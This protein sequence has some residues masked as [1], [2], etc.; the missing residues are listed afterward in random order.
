MPHHVNNMASHLRD[1]IRMSPPIFF[2]S[3]EDEDPQNFLDEVYKI[4][5]GMGVTSIEKAELAAYQLKDVGKTGYVQWRNNRALRGGLMT[6]EI[7]KKSFL[8]RFIPIE[9]M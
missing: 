5:Y 8:D 4:L 9:L 6:W 1:F 3:K 2:G 7:F